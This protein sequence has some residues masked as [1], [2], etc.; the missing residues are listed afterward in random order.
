ML[1]VTPATV[2]M[3]GNL[4][5]VLING[6]SGCTG[7]TSAAALLTVNPLPT[8]VITANPI[9]IGPTQTTTILST[10]TPNPA[11]T[12]TWYYNNSVLPGAVSSSLLVSYGS[13]GDYQLKVTDVN[14]C[15]NLSNII[16]IANSFALNMYTYPNPSGGIF[17]VRYHSEPNNTL[18]R[19]LTVYNNR[20]EK[21]I[22]RNF[23]QTIPFQKIDIDVRANGKGLYWVEVRDANGKRLGMNRVVVQ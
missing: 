5:R 6:G 15:T 1:F 8:I 13:P 20:G 14:V 10:V 11:A 16:T 2:A 21:I 23:T 22:T 3:N 19:S 12:Y 9:I 17:Q 4:F 7:A 18:Q